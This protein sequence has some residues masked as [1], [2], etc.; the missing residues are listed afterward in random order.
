MAE[1]SEL[2]KHL[3]AQAK[4]YATFVAV[5]PIFHNGARAYNPGD[6]VPAS[7]VEA[8]GYEADGLVAKSSTKAAQAVTNPD[9]V[10][11]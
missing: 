8:Y 10:K 11:G 1:L 2:D 5:S 6:P 3:E 7:N 9:E 4:E